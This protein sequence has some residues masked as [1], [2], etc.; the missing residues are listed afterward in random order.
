MAQAAWKSSAK[1]GI[2]RC[3]RRRASGLRRGG[4]FPP[5]LSMVV[6]FKELSEAHSARS[7]DDRADPAALRT[8][9]HRKGWGHGQEASHHR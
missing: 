6:V 4:R 5:W 9:G 3:F 7:E 2:E 8:V 1:A